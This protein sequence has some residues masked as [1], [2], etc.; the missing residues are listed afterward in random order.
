MEHVC[1]KIPHKVNT[2]EGLDSLGVVNAH[3]EK[4]DG[5]W[6]AHN[7]TYYIPISFCPLCGI[8]LATL[9]TKPKTLFRYDP[10]KPW[11]N[12]LL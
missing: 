7:G 5:V 2:P 11:D 3:I 8:E 6:M 4:I 12:E 9:E 1:S 10:K